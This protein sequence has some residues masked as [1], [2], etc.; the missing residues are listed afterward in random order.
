MKSEPT[1]LEQLIEDNIY[2]KSIIQARQ[3]PERRD[4]LNGRWY[5]YKGKFKRSWTTIVGETLRKGYGWD[6]WLGNATSYKDAME[7]ANERADLGSRLHTIFANLIWG[8]EISLRGLEEEEIKR[9]LEFK[10]FWL[11]AKPIQLATEYPMWHD[12]I[13]YAGT[14]DLICDIVNK[15]GIKERWLLDWKTGE[16]YDRD[17]QYQL[18]SYTHLAEKV[19]NFK[20]DRTAMVQFKGTHRK[21]CG[22]KDDKRYTFKEYDIVPYEEIQAILTLWNR[23][24]IVPKFPE[25]YPDKISLKEIIE[26]KK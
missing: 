20:I 25:K 6:K 1:E 5:E 22:V 4:D 19:F 13:P 18:S 3:I 12:D 14:A 9:I 10:Q 21:P 26:E 11:Q 24:G 23:L 7:Y 2:K 8:S 15:K 17:F 16:K